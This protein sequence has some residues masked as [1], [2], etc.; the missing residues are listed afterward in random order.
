MER[1]KISGSVKVFF[2]KY[3]Y[4]VIVLLV[5]IVLMCLP[6]KDTG[7][8]SES[9]VI[10]SEK[11][12]DTARDLERI[13]SQVKGAGEVRVL[14]TR[15]QGEKT[16]YQTDRSGDGGNV[17]TVVVTGADRTQ[18][19]LIR[20]VDPPV[21]LGAVIVCQGGDDPA[22]RLAIVEAVSDATGLGADRIT[23]LKMK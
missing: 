8:E 12:A 22:V 6:G 3:R 17:D 5:G 1:L 20:Q 23:V 4:V 18:Q 21:Y 11:T 13:L 15:S 19:G 7:I 14:L 9:T 2:K 10:A 16:I